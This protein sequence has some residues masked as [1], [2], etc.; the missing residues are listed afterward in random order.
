MTAGQ[1]SKI[2]FNFEIRSYEN[3]CQGNYD[4]MNL[5]RGNYSMRLSI[6]AVIN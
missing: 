4:G 2:Y 3:D 6:Q 5:A 1:S